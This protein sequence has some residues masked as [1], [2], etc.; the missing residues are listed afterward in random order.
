MSES[1]PPGHSLQAT[2]LVNGRRF[3]DLASWRARARI[4]LRRGRD[5]A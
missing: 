4:L 3:R 2:A 5:S 1:Q